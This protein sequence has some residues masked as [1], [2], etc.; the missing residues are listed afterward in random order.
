M[1]DSFVASSL[2]T[3]VI[4]LIALLAI[5]PLA[6][7]APPEAPS[8]KGAPVRMLDAR[9]N[10]EQAYRNAIEPRGAAAANG[11]SAAQSHSA[12]IAE[13]IRDTKKTIPGLETSLSKETG[14]P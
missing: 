3:A 2:R 6:A 8:E 12:A 9:V 11:L 10:A 14:G 1:H 4:F 13:A 7:V 5:Q